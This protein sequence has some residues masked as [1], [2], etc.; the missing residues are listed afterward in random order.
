MVFIRWTKLLVLPTVIAVGIE[1][2][3][4]LQIRRYM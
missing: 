3:Q 2:N 1:L 4:N